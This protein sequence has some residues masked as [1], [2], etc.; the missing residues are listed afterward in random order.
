MTT[1]HPFLERAAQHTA[2]A[3]A[4][5]D[6]FEGKAMPAEAANQMEKHLQKA[7]EY[8]RQVEREAALKSTEEWL[9][10]PQYKHDMTGGS[11]IAAEFGHGAP[12]LA[13]EKKEAAKSAFFDYV[14]KG[15][16]GLTI[17]QKAALV[18]DSDGNKLIPT[19]FAGTILKDLPRDAVYRGMAFV[20]PTTKRQVDV[21]SVLVSAASWGK[22]EL[23]DTAS[24]GLGSPAANKDTITVWDLNALVKL[25]VDELDDSDEG[26][27]ELIRSA[28][29]LKL[30]EQEDDAFASGTGDANKM[31]LGISATGSGIT[32][33]VTAA[34]AGTLVFDDL[35]KVTYSVPAWARRRGKWVGNSTLEQAVALVKNGDGDY[36]WRE[37]VRDGLPARLLGYEWQAMDGLPAFTSDATASKCAFFGDHYSGYMIADRRQIGVTRLAERFADEGKV[38]LIFRHRVG[39]GVIRPKALAFLNV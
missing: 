13:S 20:R 30:A 11:A 32:Q 36:I 16:S 34:A 5:N 6:E 2:Q 1:V 14:R 27:E 10:E 9:E 18:E 3:R 25:G 29:S 26:L 31:P 8:R 23:G 7:S 17:E 35:V 22:L 28:V 4:I 37:S 38:G 24:D 15:E 39:G 21:G 12:I 33:G 19:D